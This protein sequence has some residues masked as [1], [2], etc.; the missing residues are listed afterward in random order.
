MGVRKRIR[1]KGYGLD[2]SLLSL[3]HAS[4]NISNHQK[5][6]IIKFTYIKSKFWRSLAA[7]PEPRTDLHFLLNG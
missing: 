2:F 6:K 4:Q 1:P 5:I 7:P 3:E